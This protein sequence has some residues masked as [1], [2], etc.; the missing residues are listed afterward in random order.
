[1]RIYVLQSPTL[2]PS[3]KTGEDQDLKPANM[4]GLSPLPHFGGGGLGVGAKCGKQPQR[5]RHC[6]LIL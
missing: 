3:P 4:L 5:I 6:M 2:N 1:M